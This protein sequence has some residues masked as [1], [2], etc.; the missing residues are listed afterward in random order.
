M[1]FLKY[2]LMV[3]VLMTLTACGAKEET[4]V[5]E[6]YDVKSAIHLK[7]NKSEVKELEIVYV[8]EDNIY[9]ADFDEVVYDLDLDF[10][11][12]KL[13]K[14][15]IEKLENELL[16]E[17]IIGRND[18]FD[19]ENLDADVTVKQKGDMLEVHIKINERIL[20]GK[21]EFLDMPE[22]TTYREYDE[23]I[24]KDMEYERQ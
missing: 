22:G 18:K 8:M 4:Y 12:G 6:D 17:E 13:S 14:R 3:V 5:K 9:T 11:D 10:K 7:H 20:N 2:M 19:S 21:S 16:N 1:K 15:D 23:Y 24:T